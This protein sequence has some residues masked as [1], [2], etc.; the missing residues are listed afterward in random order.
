MM[1]LFVLS[2]LLILTCVFIIT[3]QTNAGAS[4]KT[5]T[6]GGM[7]MDIY[8]YKKDRIVKM[9]KIEKTD[10][11]W[12]EQLTEDQY[13]ILREEGTER[14]FSHLLNDN[15]KRGVYKSAASGV[16]LF[17][18]DHKFDSGTGWPSFFDVIAKENI[19]LRE[20]KTLLMKRTEVVDKISGSHLGHVFQDGPEP[21][22]LRYCI[23]GAALI[24][25]ET[26]Q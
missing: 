5:Y 21:T 14:P 20:D 16:A 13:H 23:N 7:I 22:G 24:F 1:K 15:K 12:R 19:E 2:V 3:Q 26:D 9:Q 17:H 6:K 18:S 11:Q 10:E 25:E 4:K 8:D